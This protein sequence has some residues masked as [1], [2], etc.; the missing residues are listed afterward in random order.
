MKPVT[1][2]WKKGSGKARINWFVDAEPEKK[3]LNIIKGS[4][5]LLNVKW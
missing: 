5:P 3:H 1:E 2:T 4:C